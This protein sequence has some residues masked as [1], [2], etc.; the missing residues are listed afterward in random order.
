MRAVDQ[1]RMPP[2]GQKF[3][4]QR[5][6]QWEPSGAVVAW[7]NNNRLKL[8]IGKYLQLRMNSIKKTQHFFRGF[9]FDAHGNTKST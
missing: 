8:G 4:Q 9:A 1:N 7:Q 3:C 2:V 5:R 6:E